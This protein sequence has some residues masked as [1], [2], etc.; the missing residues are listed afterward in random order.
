MEE[1]G[2][3]GTGRERERGEGRVRGRQG[4]RGGEGESETGRERGR[5]IGT[6]NLRKEECQTADSCW[7]WLSSAEGCATGGVAFFLRRMGLFWGTSSSCSV[8][9]RASPVHAA[10]VRL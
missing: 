5:V 8:R 10:W 6:L 9:N 4:E 1:G 7:W 2:T 3:E